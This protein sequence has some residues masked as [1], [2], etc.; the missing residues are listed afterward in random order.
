MEDA[1]FICQIHSFGGDR[2]PQYD[3]IRSEDSPKDAE[4]LKTQILSKL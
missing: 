2:Y 4:E 3:C 1:P